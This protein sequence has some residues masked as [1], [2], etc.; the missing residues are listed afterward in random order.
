M[1]LSAA[2]LTGC[3]VYGRCGLHGC[4]GDAEITTQVRALFNQHPA[5]EPPNL[6]Q[7]QTLDHVVYLYGMVDTGME[8]DLAVSIASAV[9]GVRQ[10]Q[11][12]IVV[13]CGR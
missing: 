13:C 9:P 7:V 2:S 12:S 11:N 8:S 5:L 4:P 3:A 10:V 1:V 6:L